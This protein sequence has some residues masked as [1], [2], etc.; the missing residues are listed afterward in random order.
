M[1]VGQDGAPVDRAIGERIRRRR[2]ELGLTQEQLARRLGLSYQQIQK[3][4]RGANR[5]SASRLY[6]LALRLDVAPGY[7]YADLEAPAEVLRDDGH[8]AAAAGEVA[9]TY[10]DIADDGIRAAVAGLLRAV[11]ERRT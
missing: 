2:V 3:Y 6:A 7:F 4:E 10:T 1:T 9:R 8:D 11:A 5:I